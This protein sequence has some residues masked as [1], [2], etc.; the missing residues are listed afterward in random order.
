MKEKLLVEEGVRGGGDW[1]GHP[2]SLYFN[3]FSSPCL[4]PRKKGF[5]FSLS[6]A[7]DPG[8]PRF[9]LEK[10]WRFET[11]LFSSLRELMAAALFRFCL[12]SL[13]T[14]VEPFYEMADDSYLKEVDGERVKMNWRR[15][16]DKRNADRHTQADIRK[17]ADNK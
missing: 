17:Q 16:N 9:K 4:T 13:M 1:G 11:K 3:S 6:A 5:N 2:H 10:K 12:L 15:Q 14:G 7:L 8:W